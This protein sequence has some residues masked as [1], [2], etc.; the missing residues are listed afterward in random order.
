[1]RFARTYVFAFLSL[2]L[3]FPVFSR[4][5][6]PPSTSSSPQALALL[7]NSLAALTG[8]QPINDVTLVGTA[9]RIA[10]SDDESG[11]AT[12]KALTTG[13]TRIDL[14]FASGTYTEVRAFPNSGPTGSW[15]GP[16]GV[17]HAISQHNLLTD[18]GW[19]FPALTVARMAS[20]G[21]AV[22]YVGHETIGAQAVEH[23]Y[24][25]RQFQAT[26]APSN[27]TPDAL[28]R[29]AAM[30]MYLDSTSLLPSSI[31]FKVH[32]DKND[33]ID[34][35]VTVRLSD[36]RSISGVQIHSTFRNSSTRASTSICNCKIAAS[37]PAFRPVRSLCRGRTCRALFICAQGDILCPAHHASFSRS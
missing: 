9:R 3:V 29:L 13:E 35:P 27:W 31:S 21:Y 16:D 18:S 34:I 17:I 33:L 1:M 15:V 14:V 4:Q 5:Q 30:D 20:A 37:I 24:V 19:F 23:L 25:T 22:T 2:L 8:G 32:P 36:Y 10:G 11:S 12:L 28:Q 7:Q 6:A 26:G